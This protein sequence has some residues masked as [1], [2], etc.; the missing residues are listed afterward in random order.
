MFLKLAQHVCSDTWDEYSADE[1]PGIPKQ[2][3]SNN[4]GVFVLM[5]A[6]YIVMEGHFDFDESDMHVLRHWWCI[7]LLTNYPLKSDAERKS[8]R[9]RMR[10]QRAEAIDPV[11]A[12]D[13]LTTMPPEILRQILLKVI[14]EDGDVAF[15]RLSLT[16]RIFKEIVSNA[17][18]R[19]QAHYI[20]LDSVINWSRFSEDYKKE[21]RVP[22]SLTEC[23]ECGDIFKD[24][25]PG[26]V[27][28]GRKGVLRGFYSTI[29]FPGYCSAECHFNAGG[30]FPYDNI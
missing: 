26:Y 2:H 30:E 21:F 12:D 3:C 7:V 27:G 29:D 9:K 4:C 5:Y 20:W 25:P 18:F 23:P 8:L 6:L 1:I 11:P 19:E 15:L 28:D 13:Y 10:T 22:Y 24:C 17:K 16:C 14:T